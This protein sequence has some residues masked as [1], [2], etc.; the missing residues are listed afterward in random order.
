MPPKVSRPCG[1]YAAYHRH[2][3]HREE[4]CGP[5]LAAS[6]A[7]ST[8]YQRRMRQDE[9]WRADYNARV[10]AR[11]R[12]RTRLAAEYPQ[13]YDR[14][15][16]ELGRTTPARRALARLYPQRYHELACAELAGLTFGSQ[17]TGEEEGRGGA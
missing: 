1:T 4:P 10:G 7:V 13:E 17:D 6:A 5:C 14:L 8:A 3:Y 12:A 9:A 2:L 16:A 11:R 15:F